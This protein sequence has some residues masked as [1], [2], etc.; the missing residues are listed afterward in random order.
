MLTRSR[1]SGKKMSRFVSK[2]SRF[3]DGP[4]RSR[5]FVGSERHAFLH[6]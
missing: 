2:R 5:A 1:F 3:F 6:G 4:L